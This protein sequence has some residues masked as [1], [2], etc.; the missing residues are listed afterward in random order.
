MKYDKRL[1]LPSLFVLAAAGFLLPFWP[2]SVLAVVTGGLLGHGMFAFVLG[3][4]LD[5]AWGAPTGA[6]HVLVF[7]F[8]LLALLSILARVFAHRFLLRKSLPEKL[9]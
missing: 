1:V 8:T 9:Y 6:L 5:V 2:F 7:P 4:L 3:L